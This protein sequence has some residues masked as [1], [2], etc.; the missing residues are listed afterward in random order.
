MKE[1]SITIYDV[2]R[3][4]GVSTMTVSRAMREGEREAVAEE[5]RRRIRRIA[6][7]LNYR[8]HTQARGLVSRK[9]FNVG[10]CVNSHGFSY[11]SHL[12]QPLLSVVQSELNRC[13]YHFGFYYFKPGL[14][15][16]F[17]TFIN[18]RRV[19]D[20]IIIHGR[21]F[22]PEE[23][24]AIRSSGIIAVSLFEKISGMH[25]LLIDDFR[26]GRL[27]ADFLWERGFRKVAFIAYWVGGP[28][29]VEWN[30]LIMGF[31]QRAEEL[32][33][34]IIEVKGYWDDRY[35]PLYAW[36]NGHVRPDI[37]DYLDRL[38]DSE[39]C[40]FCTSDSFALG[41]LRE[42]DR[43]GMREGEDYSVLGYDNAESYG[44]GPRSEPRL[45]TIDRPRES[46]GMRA[47][48]LAM[49]MDETVKGPVTE[50]FPV[51][52][53]ERGSVGYGKR[54]WDVGG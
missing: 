6:R 30:G 4:A 3:A 20:A 26:G 53:M 17:L 27:A 38:G 23:R 10:F 37:F 5:T 48:V 8:P 42:M 31:R 46:I 28:E 51:S 52:L 34:E 22:C 41:M 44:L 24:E 18:D 19:V 13:G 1:G 54:R 14:D 43:L 49:E 40:V 7:E 29:K 15:P 47:A 35:D 11:Y 39:R 33:L 16:E 36:N 45:T 12:H 9:A 50:T 21:D 25:S 32:G 2:A